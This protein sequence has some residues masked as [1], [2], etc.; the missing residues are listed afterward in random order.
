M[1]RA[2]AARIAFPLSWLLGFSSSSD[3]KSGVKVPWPCDPFK[4]EPG[5]I[6]LNFDVPLFANR[7]H[8][9]SD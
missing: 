6:M 3:A 2:T 1:G 9:I 8:I 4:A 5:G 7:L